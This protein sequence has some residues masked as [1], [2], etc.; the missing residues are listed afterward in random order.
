M[1]LANGTLAYA[2]PNAGGRSNMT[3]FTSVPT[4]GNDDVNMSSQT[5]QFPPDTGPMYDNMCSRGE[6][7]DGNN[8]EV[9]E[10]VYSGP[11][12]YSALA[13][14]ENGAVL[15]AYERDV[16]GCSGESCSIE[17]VSL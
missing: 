14:R 1:T 5:L 9:A 17:W 6:E 11:S 16:T 7:D 2:A 3:V 8:W 13:Q 10:H 4:P 12:A 15:L